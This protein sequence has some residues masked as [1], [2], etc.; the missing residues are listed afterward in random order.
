ME[1]AEEEIFSVICLGL[2][3]S[4]PTGLLDGVSMAL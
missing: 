3:S 4:P 2:F 1:Y